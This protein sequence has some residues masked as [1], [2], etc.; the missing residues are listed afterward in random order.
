MFLCYFLELHYLCVHVRRP[1]DRAH[2]HVILKQ[3]AGG[4]NRYVLYIGIG[5]HV[6]S[7]Q[8]RPL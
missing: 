3:Q 5:M 2:D 6:N 1:R 8:D 4:N 7:K